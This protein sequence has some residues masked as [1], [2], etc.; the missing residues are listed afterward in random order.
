MVIFIDVSE[1]VSE[2]LCFDKGSKLNSCH[3]HKTLKRRISCSAIQGHAFR[4]KTTDVSE[5]HVASILRGGHIVFIFQDE[6][7]HVRTAGRHA[8]IRTEYFSYTSLEYW[9]SKFS[10]PEDPLT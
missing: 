9:L 7:E 4:W 6:H 1:N 10:S 5:E 3:I 2:Y 8:E